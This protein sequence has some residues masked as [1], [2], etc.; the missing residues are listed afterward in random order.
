MTEITLIINKLARSA[1]A[2]IIISES[3]VQSDLD[4][5]MSN[6]STDSHKIIC[7]Q[8]SS[9]LFLRFATGH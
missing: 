2:P 6:Q 5:T 1:S 8:V 9:I 4:S 7:L 3:L